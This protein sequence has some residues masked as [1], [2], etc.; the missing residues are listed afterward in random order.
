MVQ[1]THVILPICGVI[2]VGTIA[3]LFWLRRHHT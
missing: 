2:V 1:Y 3:W